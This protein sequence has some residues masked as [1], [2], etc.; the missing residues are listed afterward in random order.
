M[1][2]AIAEIEPENP[3]RWS[4]LHYDHNACVPHKGVIDGSAV[5]ILPTGLSL[6]DFK[7]VIWQ[8]SPDIVE[9]LLEHVLIVC[10]YSKIG[11]II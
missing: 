11:S 3:N 4:T 10:H 1:F 6:V 5:K 9:A 7:R 8:F 2:N